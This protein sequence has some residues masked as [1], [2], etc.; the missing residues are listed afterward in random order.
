MSS[1]KKQNKS[2]LDNILEETS[3]EEMKKTEK[4]ML[5]AA[6]IDDAIKAKGWRKKDFAKAMNKLPSE[7]SKWLSGTHNFNTDTLYDIEEVLGI[8][9]INTKNQFEQTQTYH[10]SAIT[11][12][13]NQSFLQLNTS[14]P[15][16]ERVQ[17]STKKTDDTKQKVNKEF[18]EFA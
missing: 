18:P 4:R 7:I 15:Y 8:E 3:P 6:K 5:L 16:T 17:P 14:L 1:P 12:V 2:V 9:L 10:Y 11:E 13:T